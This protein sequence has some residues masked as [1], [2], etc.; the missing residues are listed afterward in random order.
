M[1]LCSDL[2]IWHWV[3]N[4]ILYL[5]DRIT[6]VGPSHRPLATVKVASMRLNYGAGLKSNWK[7][8]GYS[9]GVCIIIVEMGISCQVGHI[10]T[11]WAEG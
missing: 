11:H 4:V 3:V 10:V 2:T 8:V 9:D 1:I 7:V 5:F 6:L